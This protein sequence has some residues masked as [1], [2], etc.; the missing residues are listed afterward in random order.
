MATRGIRNNNPGNIERGA[1]WQG[2]MEPDRMTPRQAAETRFAV[3]RSP[4]W[5]IRAIAR[6]LITYQDKHGLNTVRGI[7]DRWAP[8]VENDT[9]AYVAAVEAK[10]G[11]GEIDV[12]D[13]ATMNALVR[14]IVLH[15]NGSQPYTDAQIDAGLVLAGIEPPQRRLARTGTVRGGQVATITQTVTAATGLVAA[16]APALPVL[17]YIKQNLWLLGVFGAL[18]LCATGYIIWRRIDDRRRGLR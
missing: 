7:I 14:A 18:G 1:P 12:H 6:T 15:E 2:L 16:V 4:K 8:P 5:G 17:D 9:A 3:F 13:Y 11:D 10:A